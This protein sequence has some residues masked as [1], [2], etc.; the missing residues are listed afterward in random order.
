MG[1]GFCLVSSIVGGHMDDNTDA[2]V[3]RLAQNGVKKG[4]RVSIFMVFGRFSAR[5]QPIAA[6]FDV[7][8]RPAII[9]FL[10]H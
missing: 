5:T 6:A 1:R 7:E 2:A 10:R 9:F 8:C 4:G 3:A